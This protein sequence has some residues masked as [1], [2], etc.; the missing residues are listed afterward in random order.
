MNAQHLFQHRTTLPDLD[1]V[2]R[3]A[4]E[5][6]SELS[7]QAI[8]DHGGFHVALSGGSTPKRLYQLLAT[9]P[10]SEQNDWA[11]TH[12]YFGDERSVPHHHPES[13]FRM[14]REALLDHVDIPAEQIH[15]IPSNPETI[16]QGAEAYA[17]LLA[18]QLPGGCF[19][20]L[21]LGM[22][23]DGH[24]ASLFP[25]TTILNDDQHLATA[26]YVDKF[27]SWRISITLPLINRAQH[28]LLLVCGANK[29]EALRH[30]TADATPLLPIQRLEPAGKL[31]WYLDEAAAVGLKELS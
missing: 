25:E 15:P 7:R 22:G 21:L 16:H 31:E 19:D 2:S 23:P 26:V 14:A 1:A 28:T 12:V 5:R 3:R 27:K 4:A 8:A 24:T 29:V 9:T 10:F 17:T 13:N 11:H 20:L 18:D 30:A 6:W